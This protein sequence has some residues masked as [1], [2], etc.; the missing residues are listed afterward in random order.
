MRK[1][2]I[3]IVSVL[4]LVF[5]TACG[6]KDEQPEGGQF[7]TGN[8]SGQFPTGSTGGQQLDVVLDENDFPDI[9]AELSGGTFLGMQ[10]YKGEPVQLWA[11]GQRGAMPYPYICTGRT[12]R[13]R[14]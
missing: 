7:P 14:P 2:K 9:A 11:S 8:E 10:F 13:E 3:F 5:L 4:C 1:V 6:G 12:K